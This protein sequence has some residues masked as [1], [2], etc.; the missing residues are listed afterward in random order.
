MDW[1][2]YSPDLNPIEHCW[3]LLKNNMHVVERG[4]LLAASGRDGI[5]TALG[6]VLPVAWEEIS[7][8]HLQKLIKSMKKRIKAVINA[9]GW[10]T[11]Y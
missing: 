11:K 4:R 8:E 6:Q 3:F 2:P 5:R 10:Y 1:P 9:D 7:E